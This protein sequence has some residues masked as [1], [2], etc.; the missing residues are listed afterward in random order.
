VTP[1]HNEKQD[2]MLQ[3]S[4][5]L[6]ELHEYAGSQ[7][8]LMADDLLLFLYRLRDRYRVLRPSGDRSKGTSLGFLPDILYQFESRPDA[9]LQSEEWRSR[10]E[11]ILHDLAEGKLTIS[12]KGNG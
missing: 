10:I 3:A 5:L 2:L 6:K 9:T 4:F 12:I 1:G 8:D 11:S 7:R